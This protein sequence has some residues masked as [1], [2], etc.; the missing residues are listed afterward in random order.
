MKISGYDGFFLEENKWV[1]LL[2]REVRV[3]QELE[4]R[5][6]WTLEVNLSVGP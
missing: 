1:C 3:D 5:S 4:L 2:I 6:N